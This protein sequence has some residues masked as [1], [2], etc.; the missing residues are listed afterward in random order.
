MFTTKIP[1]YR[2]LLLTVFAGISSLTMIAVPVALAQGAGPAAQGSLNQTAVNFVSML[3]MVNTFMHI[4]ILI[5][6]NMLQY[7]LQADYF[8]D[9]HMMSALNQIWVLS[10]NIMNVIFAMMLIGVALY[11][12]ITAKSELI[13]NKIATFILAV[14]LVN[15]SWFFPRVIIDVA[16][17]MTSTVYS[18]PNLLSPFSCQAFGG[19]KCEVITDILIMPREGS[20]DVALWRAKN[21]CDPPLPQG[22]YPQCSCTT[23]LGCYLKEDYEVAKNKVGAGH[24]MINGMATT[25]IRIDML[26]QIPTKIATAENQQGL[27]KFSTTL[28]IVMNVMMT[29]FIQ[30]GVLL[31]L[32]GLAVG[33]FIRIL[34][35]WITIAFMPFTFLGLVINGKIG[36]NIF[37]FETDVWHEFIVAA[38]LP[39]VVAIP[40]VIGFIMLSTS[41]SVPEP[42]GFGQTWSVPLLNGVGSWW[43][44]LWMFA[45]IGIL[46]VGAFT[47]L[48]RS[49]ITGK[50][51]ERIKGFGET[52]FGT[53]MQIP[54]IIPLPVGIG[55]KGANLGTLVHGPRHLQQAI[56]ARSLGIPQTGP[57]DGKVDASKVEALNRNDAN[58][59]LIVEA[60]KKIADGANRS[61]RSKAILEIQ[62]VIGGHGATHTD[63][64]EQLKRIVGERG[65][66]AL[67]A[68]LD[69]L[70]E[71]IRQAREDKA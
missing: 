58:T 43:P 21:S 51:T 52:V 5:V 30:A 61:D 14:V 54:L 24:A 62:S 44:Y 34:I 31:P 39:T 29:L 23:G 28:G 27:Q 71:A 2:R 16:N 4:L 11:T 9:P 6:L 10:R 25:F 7:L 64:L 46:W 49:K 55:P 57:R 60:I 20:T 70:D 68:K 32:L 36:T 47:A 40:M 56:Q 63:T 59:R 15:F 65:D 1:F 17:I 38:F 26:S 67:K 18:I 42:S 69:K 53:A 41:A 33:F 12:I 8:N 35:L 45:A 66:P 19:G 3:A 50:I 48:A 22:S 37:G 13:K